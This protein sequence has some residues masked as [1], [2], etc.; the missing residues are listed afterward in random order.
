VRTSAST[1]VRRLITVMLVLA[2]ALATGTEA[3]S[4]G[5]ISSSINGGLVQLRGNDGCIVAIPSRLRGC[6]RAR[7]MRGPAPFTGSDAVAV[8]PDGRDVYVAASSSNAITVLRRY[9]PRGVLRQAPGRRG[10]ISERGRGGCARAQGLR[11]PVSVAISRNGRKVYAASMLGNSIT[12]F[13]RNPRTGALSQDECIADASARVPGCGTGNGLRGANVV[14]ISPDGRNIYVGGFTGNT[15]AVFT[16]GDAGGLDQTGCVADA[17]TPTTG[18]TPVT[19]LL[20][21]EGLGVS[22]DGRNVYVGS[23][24]GGTVTAFARDRSTGAISQLPLPAGCIADQGAP[25]AGCGTAKAVQGADAVAISRDGRNVYVAAGIGDGL[26]IFSRDAQSGA[27]SQLPTTTG[28]WVAV[29][30]MDCALGQAFKVPEGVAVTPDGANVYVGAFGS[31]AVAIFDRSGQN[32]ALSQ[33]RRPRGCIVN[34][35]RPLCTTGRALDEANA[36]AVS[37][38]GA[39]VYV[40]AVGSNSIG[41][42]SRVGPDGRPRRANG[43]RLPRGDRD[44]RGG[45]RNRGGGGGDRGGGGGQNGGGRGPSGLT[46]STGR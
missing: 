12:S 30:A 37:P 39:N 32:G 6:D 4:A 2:A 36:I 33:K 41:V 38:D 31:S 46:G 26:A 23:A 27:L 5:A 24:L 35:P 1:A 44:R 10:C 14:S 16:Q 20:G 21:P 29:L 28:C 22:P 3:A 7:A 25:I 34:A 11:R 40:G 8:S 15:V 13:T 42:F 18:C 19:G 43:N 9:A 17:G 45:D